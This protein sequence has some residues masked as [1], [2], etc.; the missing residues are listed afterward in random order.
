M[1]NRYLLTSIYDLIVTLK[2]PHILTTPESFKTGT[3]G[4]AQLDE[5]IFSNDTYLFQLIQCFF[6]L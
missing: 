6:Y 2:S 3:I 5:L 4:E 1:D